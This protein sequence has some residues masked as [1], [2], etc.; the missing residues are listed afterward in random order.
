MKKRRKRLLAL[1][2]AAA[3]S[4]SLFSGMSFVQASEGDSSE[5]TETD[6]S[7]SYEPWAHGYRFVDILNWN[8]DYDDYSDEMQARVPLQ[9]RNED[10]AAT[11]ADPSLSTD[12]QIYAI[13]SGNYRSTDTAEA[14]WNANMSYDDFSYNAF[15]MWQY[16]DYVGAGGRPTSG[17]SVGAADKE[18]GVIALPQA[19]A[20]NAAHKNGVKAIGEYFIPR[21]PQ[22]T[23]EWLY[24]DED[25]NFPYAQKLVDIMNYYGFDGYFINQE[26]AIEASYVPLFREMLKWMRDQGCYIQWYD[27]ILDSGRISY[28]NLFNSNNSNWVYNETDGRVSDSIFLN[29]W[30][31]DDRDGLMESAE[32][33]ESLGLNPRDA[34]FYGVEGGQWKFGQNLDLDRIVDDNGEV[35]MS[36]AIWGSDFY[37]EQYNKAGDK[38][39]ESGYQ[40]ASEERERLYY[41]GLTEDAA[42][43]STDVDRSDVEVETDSVWKG[44]SA[45]TAEKTVINGSTFNSDFNNGHGMQYWENGEVSRD[46]EW[47][48]DNLQDILPTWQWWVT[49]KDDNKLDLD[50]DYGKNLKKIMTDGSEGDFGYDQIGAYNGGSSLVMWGDVKDSQTIHLYK[51]DL[52]VTAASKLA[53]T[54]NKVSAN[55]SSKLQLSLVFKDDPDHTILVPVDMTG[56]QTD[57]WV[58]AQV[59]LEDYAGRELAAIGL[60]V[61]AETQV[62]DYQLNLGGLKLTDGKSYAPSAPTNLSISKNLA[63]TGEVQLKW[64]LDSYDEVQLYRIYA[65]YKDGT[66]RFVGGVYGDNYYIENLENREE[67]KALNLYAIG[68]DGSASE[69]ATVPFNTGLTVNN[70]KAVSED[71]KLSV[72]WEEPEGDY[73][74]TEVSLDYWY[75]D[76]ENPETITVTKGTEKA[77]FAIDVEDGEK[78]ILSIT[79]VNADGSKN[80]TMNYYGELA[81]HYCAPYSGSARKNAAGD[82]VNLTTPLPED[83]N[84]A[85]VDTNGTRT[86]Y[87]RFGGKSMMN[88]NVGTGFSSIT[89][90]LEDS[91]GNTSIPA[92]MFFEDGEQIDSSEEY[93]DNMFPDATLRAAVREQIGDTYEDLTAFAGELNLS[94]MNVKDLTGIN[95]LIQL[96]GI[97]LSNSGIKE[98]NKG[99]FPMSVKT[100]NLSGCEQLLE[101]KEDAVAAMTNLTQ[102]D[103]S[104]C[105]ALEKVYLNQSSEK[106]A[107]DMKG[108][109]AVEELYLTE[110]GMKSFDISE[111]K[112]LAI[113]NANNSKLETLVTAD[114][115]SYT[116]AY[117]FDLS[118]SCFDFTKGTPE[119]KFVDE[120]S[121][122]IEEHPLDTRYGKITNVASAATVLPGSTISRMESILQNNGYTWTSIGEAVLDLGEMLP[123]KGWSITNVYLPTYGIKGMSLAYSSNQVD[124]TAFGEAA[125]DMEDSTEVELE[126][127]VMARYIKVSFSDFYGS[128][129][130]IYGDFIVNGRQAVE[131]GVSYKGQTPS[132][133]FGEKTEAL[134][135]LQ[136]T[137]E[138]IR[139]KD[140]FEAYYNDAVT[141]RG[142]KIAD[143]TDVSW[144]D[145]NY[146]IKADAAVPAKTYV[147][148]YDK[149]GNQINKIEDTSEKPDTTT[150]VALNA[151]ILGGSGQNDGEGYANL[152]DGQ[153]AG[154]KWCT[155]ASSGY[156]AFALANPETIGKWITT[157]AGEG[158]GA[159]DFNTADFELQVLNTE[160]VGMSEE[161]FLNS[162]YA[163][164]ISNDSNWTT[165]CHVK[166]NF[167]NISTVT[168]DQT[169]EARVYRLKVNKAQQGANYI[170]IRIYEMALYREDTTP[171]DYEGMLKLDT[172]GQ[173]TVKFVKNDNVL[174]E[175]KVDVVDRM[176]DATE[177]I[178][179]V[180][181]A[182]GMKQTL[183]TKNTTGALQKALQAGKDIIADVNATEDEIKTATG[184]LKAAINGMRLNLSD[185]L[186]QASALDLKK[187]TVDSAATL[188]Q[189]IEAAQKA[190]EKPVDESA[191][192][193]A[194]L[195]LRIAMNSLVIAPAEKTEQEELNKQQSVITETINT[196]INS[197]KEVVQ[198]TLP[199][200]TVLTKEDI[201]LI[202]NAG[203]KLTIN[204]NRVD[205]KFESIDKIMEFNP[206]VTIGSTIKGMSDALKNAK[207]SN[208][209]KLATVSF[210]FDG[211]LLGKAEVTLDLT[212]YGFAENE[213]VYLYYL[214]PEKNTLELT[215]EGVCVGNKAAFNITHCSDYVITNEK[216]A[217][218]TP[219]TGDTNTATI[220]LLV[221]AAGM[222]L[223]SFAR[224]R[225]KAN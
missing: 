3:V 168:L 169:Q 74:K 14:P 19:A 176:N 156:M 13:S 91:L 112:S 11:Q 136:N 92:T 40:W 80:A 60:D 119:R 163:G 195:Q 51:T 104:G 107:V 75:S 201:T 39:Y 213:K 99:T 97:D 63:D 36:I 224:K 184:A 211:E 47:T 65:E 205:W 101:I 177:L 113:L 50:W 198:V 64:N 171:R 24:K 18:Y 116:N 79:T 124:W 131:M 16:V 143:M 185:L 222:V 29:Y 132:I 155:G 66:E 215:D 218:Q 223:I 147:E 42:D 170:A 94:G 12:V 189:A 96:S 217:V 26:E 121:T 84:I 110:T 216:L 187:Y 72:S 25:G 148:V 206:Q 204:A 10:F 140:Y 68:K 133:Y 183:Y 182:E 145:E 134:K 59:S 82:G 130:L 7:L 178:G 105:T 23:Q 122:Y 57:G 41:T 103:L 73:Q 197:N 157:H 118:G 111:L 35:A 6:S 98:V 193:S 174:Q 188:K 33:A 9:E 77:E 179:L 219:E 194:E 220:W 202:K 117:F 53:L 34:I 38:R 15:K 180:E 191:V 49:S 106:L 138:S 1:C 52:D 144:V 123:I 199:A 128:R 153:I 152:F 142:T 203:K 135:E 78:Y 58:T 69:A 166:N 129:P 200:N 196:Q 70:I 61:S 164:S 95:N 93:A 30:N 173:Y 32:Y 86:T 120:L 22:Y 149:D 88:I 46:M 192:E 37:R 102:L 221:L 100:L 44:F 146:D 160:A 67:I 8:P 87:K 159:A 45:Y 2:M 5:T 115:D 126:N 214:N 210:A 212:G 55:D 161:E 21:S 207:V 54:Y 154:S 165:I 27:S 125:A 48:N 17:I 151:Q 141:V 89:V 158:E 225:N 186:D 190:T 71:N 109:T 209:A 83:W 31:T 56:K 108:C 172:L 162:N 167:D 76:K 137:K 43:H 20:V 181:S 139:L 85:Y 28:Q 127:E 114:A 175:M 150:N 90:T 81:D 208:G 62:S 4:T